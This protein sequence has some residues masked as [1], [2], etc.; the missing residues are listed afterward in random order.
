MHLY[1][2]QHIAPHMNRIIKAIVYM[3]TRKGT[4]HDQEG[5]CMMKNTFLSHCDRLKY[6]VIYSKWAGMEQKYWN[7]LNEFKSKPKAF[8]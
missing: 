8:I 5:Q 3:F 1:A 2:Y 4:L 7:G 6:T